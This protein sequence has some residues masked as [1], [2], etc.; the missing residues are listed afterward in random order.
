M[1][2]YPMQANFKTVR[3]TL[4]DRDTQETQTPKYPRRSSHPSNT[5]SNSCEPHS[6]SLPSP[7]L[8]SP[9]PSLPVSKSET[10]LSYT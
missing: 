10:A 6:P 3:V 5:T 4:H 2:F 7:S 1:T 9:S 8:P